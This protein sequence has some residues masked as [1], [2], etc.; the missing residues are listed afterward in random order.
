[1]N[2]PVKTAPAWSS[3][4]SPQ[5]A[6]SNA[7]CRLPPAAT[8]TILPGDGVF[9]RE[10]ATVTRGSSAGPS[11][12]V[13]AEA[14]EIEIIRNEIVIMKMEA[15]EYMMKTPLFGY[16]DLEFKRFLS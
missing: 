6:L 8:V 11:K 9:A 16:E 2:L 10:L 3:I 7:A 1:L 12:P 13:F 14:G 5:R 4:V 15:N